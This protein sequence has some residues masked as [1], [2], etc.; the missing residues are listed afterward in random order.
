LIA[1]LS[2]FIRTTKCCACWAKYANSHVS[3]IS[4]YCATR[5]SRKERRA[6]FPVGTHWTASA[7]FADRGSR[8]APQDKATPRYE[9]LTCLGGRAYTGPN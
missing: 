7:V 3:A 4:I 2:D 9:K 5:G 8:R 6:P 1:Q